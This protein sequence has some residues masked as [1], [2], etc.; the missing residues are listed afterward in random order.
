MPRNLLS[1]LSCLSLIFGGCLSV[2]GAE[3][4]IDGDQADADAD[5]DADADSDADSD[6]GAWQP[7]GDAEVEPE[8][9]GDERFSGDDDAN[10]DGL[11]GTTL[12]NNEEDEDEDGLL[13]CADPGCH[14]APE[15]CLPLEESPIG[16]AF[17]ECVDG[18][19]ECGWSLFTADDSFRPALNADGEVLLGGD[20]RS[21]A[22]LY[23][24]AVIGLA[25]L[26]TF[27]LLASLSS[28]SCTDVRCRQ[29]LGLV[30]TAQ[31]TMSSGTGVSPLVGIIVDGEQELAHL[32]VAGRRETALD[33]TRGQLTTEHV[34][35]FRVEADGTVS[36]W[37]AL[38]PE[39]FEETGRPAETAIYRSEG[40]MDLTTTGLRVVT[41]GRLQ[42]EGAARLVGLRH[43]QRVCDM[44][45]SWRRAA[46]PVLGS[47]ALRASVG[48]P[49][50][51]AIDGEGNL[52]MVYE[53]H[54]DL[55]VA[56]S[57]DW[58][59]T[60]ETLGR[61]FADSATTRYGLVSRG[62]P[63]ILRW[64]DPFGGE[65]EPFQMWFVGEAEVDGD[66]PAGV[67]PTAIVHA[68]S[69]DGIE[70]NETDTPIV[71]ESSHECSY[72]SEV[73]D[74]TVDVVGIQQDRLTMWFV[75]RSTMTGESAILRATSSNAKDWTVV[76]TPVDFDVE[77]LRAWERDG[78]D[79]PTVLYRN[80]VYHMWYVGR[81]GAR[82]TI[83]YALS[84]DGIYWQR[85][86][87]VMSARS[88]WEAD[89][90]G[91][92]AVVE[93]GAGAGT[94]DTL[95]LWY[96]AGNPGRERLGMAWRDIPVL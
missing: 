76:E 42:G 9:P 72:C 96:E 62:S 8:V 3:D 22:G 33:L 55:Q 30:L 60:W 37:A 57:A 16:G 49:A 27:T 2:T 10:A 50:I 59:E 48:R 87:A 90:V 71:F 29:A 15:C 23:S 5:G 83:G 80:G 47:G 70:W 69:A 93:T 79:Q 64:T 26:P 58:G 81:S 46:A 56:T 94:I 28:E 95:R 41:F 39:S 77:P 6:T 24:E 54:N 44:P 74:P 84:P 89:R 38:E 92:P 21:E 78:R 7:D 25:G 12:C 82:S 40:M 1:W 18:L 68:V 51:H 31:E 32:Y 13:D 53:Q 73:R 20:G 67:T 61:A 19:E 65:S 91:G 36:F 85:Y 75:G 63:T 4:F 11:Y 88:R 14:V 34:W 17:G 66:T 52:L 45:G 43:E 35:G 86:G